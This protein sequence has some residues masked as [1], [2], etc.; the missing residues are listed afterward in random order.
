MARI[1]VIDDDKN[2]R[3]LVHEELTLAGYVVEGAADGAS[4]LAAVQENPPDLV[5]L[6]IKMPGMSGL[7]VLPRLKTCSP[8]TPVFLFTAYGDYREDATTLG[9]DGYFVKSADFSTLKDA[10]RSALDRNA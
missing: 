4:G 1:L 10:V 3:F 8:G 7:D 2:I 5:I 6:D 9:A